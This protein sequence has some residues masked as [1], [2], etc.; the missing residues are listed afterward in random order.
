MVWKGGEGGRGDVE[1]ASL[2]VLCRVSPKRE[3]L[4]GFSKNTSVQVYWCQ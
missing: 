1:K 4:R 2:D 3:I